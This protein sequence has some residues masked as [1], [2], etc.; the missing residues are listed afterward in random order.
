MKRRSNHEI[1]P[2]IWQSITLHQLQ[3]F[4][5]AARHRSFTRAAEELNLRQP[6]ISIQIKHLS[7]LIG[8]PLFENI[9]KRMYLTD[10]GKL[11][12]KTCQEIFVRIE[13]SK[14]NL[15][16]LKG[17]NHGR[18]QVAATPSSQYCL[19]KLLQPFC[20]DY[21]GIH[22]SLSWFSHKAVLDRMN[23]DLDD[24]YIMSRLPVYQREIEA[25]SFLQNPLVVIAPRQ[26]PLAQKQSITLQNLARE[27]FVMREP[28]SATRR[29]AE[30]LFEQYDIPMR[31]KLEMSNN[32]AIKQ[33]VRGGFG[34]AVMS[35][36]SLSEFE[37]DHHFVVLDVENFPIVQEWFLVFR[38]DKVLS[39]SARTFVDFLLEKS[40]GYFRV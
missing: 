35:L 11:L 36:H 16:E 6:T 3:V 40:S 17:L 38:K 7:N 2:A 14:I 20:Q 15:L 34:L 9:G 21:P 31:V 27:F 24:L 10:V 4:E 33:A 22:I 12:F 1:S 13:Q 25:R 37:L 5:V 30:S 29:A 19:A 8:S 28:D 39:T 26:H 32:E 18:L 23:A